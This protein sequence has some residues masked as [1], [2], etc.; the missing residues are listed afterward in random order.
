[1][2]LT[3]VGL[4]CCATVSLQLFAS[5]VQA[6]THDWLNNNYNISS[7]L[8]KNTE[9]MSNQLCYAVS[10]SVDG[11]TEPQEGCVFSGKGL[12]LLRS[13][14]YAAIRFGTESKFYIIQNIESGSG[15]NWCYIV[16]DSDTFVYYAPVSGEGF[17]TMVVYQHLT[18]HL[19]RAITSN[20]Q[21]TYNLDQSSP[22]FV[23]HDSLGN[24]SRVIPQTVANSNS[25]QYAIVDI[26][27]GGVMRIDVRNLQQR[28]ITGLQRHQDGDMTPWETSTAASDD[29]KYVAVAGNYS[30]QE[31]RIYQLSGS[32]GDEYIDTLTIADVCPKTTLDYSE[33][34]T[35]GYV[36]PGHSTDYVYF[37]DNDN[38]I[39]YLED[40]DNSYFHCDIDEN[41]PVC[42]G[43]LRLSIGDNNTVSAQLDYLAIGDSYTSGEGDVTKDNVS[44]YLP[45]TDYNGG[46]HLS[47]RS[48]PFLLRD[49]WSVATNKM[50]S[51]ACSGARVNED[52]LS[53]FSS[54][55]GQSAR[56]SN[57]STAERSS[58]QTN[59]LQNFT[60]GTVPQLEYIRKYKPKIVTL[61]GGGNDVGFAKIL[62]DCAADSATCSY[63]TN[64]QWIIN[65][66]VD[67]YYNTE[68]QLIQ[69]IKQTSPSSKIYIIGYPKFIKNGICVLNSGLLNSEEISMINDSVGRLNT[70]LSRAAQNTGTEFVS[71]ESSLEGGRLCEGSAYM[72]GAVNSLLSSGN[73]AAQTSFHPNAAGHQ[74]MAES[75]EAQTGKHPSRLQSTDL[76]TND[77]G[78]VALDNIAIVNYLLMTNSNVTQSSS[79]QISL[80]PFTLLPGSIVQL[81]LHSDPIDIGTLTANTDGSLS[82]TVNLPAGAPLGNHTLVLEGYSYSG[83]SLTY[84]QYLTVTSNLPNDRDADGILDAEDPCDFIPYWFDETTNKNICSTSPTISKNQS[85]IVD[86]DKSATTKETLDTAASSLITDGPISSFLEKSRN[87]LR[88][89]NDYDYHAE[90]LWL[91]WMAVS[92]ICL[93]ILVTFTS[94]VYSNHEKYHE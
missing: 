14:Y 43:L 39:L 68:L 69:R 60:P 21:I 92:S 53:G 90:D 8:T 26:A 89:T 4:F 65:K 77:F 66:T 24:V 16:P 32:C 23:L 7:S 11:Y 33:F 58:L 79:T 47:S 83:E 64:D 87:Q 31:I 17:S 50:H 67:S 3:L 29:G 44:H 56:F 15:R 85:R 73:V 2:R 28:A 9:Y 76:Y 82:G 62:R 18:T 41:S 59:A 88:P 12:E 46:C 81:F 70:V 86:K 20:S 57:L 71:T 36:Y 55:L 37:D 91:W 40:Y 42:D 13:G 19:H 27:G 80:P 74:K 49:Y 10:A 54:Y 84:Y 25:G 22:D 35:V 93:I 72:T 94:I 75:I 61:T 45:L 38:L 63:A 30:P 6:S 48:Y 52:Y 34:S 5:I 78:S 1:M 51:V